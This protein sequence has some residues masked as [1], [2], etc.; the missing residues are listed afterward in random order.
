[1]TNC[2]TCDRHQLDTAYVCADCAVRTARDLEWLAANA[3]E[4]DTVVARQ[5]RIGNP[6]GGTGSETPL[7]IDLQASY[8][9]DAVANTLVT[10]AQ[11]VL[12][13]RTHL[14]GPADTIAGCAAWLAG[15][16]EWIRHRPYAATALDELSDAAALARCIVDSHVQRVYR[17]PCGADDP[18]TGQRC[19]EDLYAPE[20]AEVVRCRACGAEHDAAARRAWLLDAVRDQLVP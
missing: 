8:D 18:N 7:P 17:G 12:E 5:S 11:D 16:T 19:D 10:W 3:S 2:D 1:M 13:H 4:M 20:T 14:T 9:R 15:Q 6:N